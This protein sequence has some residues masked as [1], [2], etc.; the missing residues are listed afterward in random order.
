MGVPRVIWP[1]LHPE[2][3]TAH[4]APQNVANHLPKPPQSPTI[5]HSQQVRQKEIL[6]I[7]LIDSYNFSTKFVYSKKVPTFVENNG[8][9]GADWNTGFRL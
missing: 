2:D 3:T 5:R 9:F 6:S 1:T 8:T 7:F 4:P